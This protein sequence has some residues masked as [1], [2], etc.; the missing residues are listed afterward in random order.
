MGNRAL[1]QSGLSL[2][3]PHDCRAFACQTGPRRSRVL[4]LLALAGLAL[5]LGLWRHHHF[6]HD[7]AYVS[8]RYAERLMVGQ[9]LTWNDGER[10]EGFSSPSWVAQVALLCGLGI[11]LP[12]AAR[13]LGVVYALATLVLWYR[14]RAEPA[15]LLALVTVSGFTM[16]AWGGLE[17]V[18]ACFWILLAMVVV[19]RVGS[20]PMSSRGGLLFGLSLALVVLSRPEGIAVGMSL[21]C[22]AWPARRGRFFRIGAACLMVV[23]LAYEIFRLAYFGDWI[24]NGARAKTLG[25]PL[26]TR[27]E[28]AAIYLAKTAPQ[29]LGAVF[30]A[31]WMLAW[32]PER[33]RACWLLLPVVP[34]LLVVVLG[35]GDHMLGA[36]FM[37]A[38]VAVM[39]LAGSLAPPSPRRWVRYCTSALATVCALA[40]FQIAWRHPAAPNPA[41]AIGEI[42]GRALEARLTPGTLVATA[43]AGSVPYFAPSLAFIDTLG[44]NDRHIARQSPAIISAARDAAENWAGVPGHLRGDGDYV[45]SRRPEVIV[46]GG[47]NGDIAPWFLGDYQVITS[48]AFQGAYAPWRLLVAVPPSLRPWVADEI[49]AETGRLPVTLYVRRD[50]SAWSAIARDAAMLSPLWASAR[51]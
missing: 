1:V 23:F 15:G 32:S 18:A 24:A 44:L 6:F 41:A 22:A 42:V 30:V 33:K 34:L 40:Q 35:G 46:L 2:A 48:K 19:Q 37:L 45:L 51:E 8:L 26:G 29:W 31:G 43:T 11:S 7:D 39:C 10:L 17:T 38:P 12:L 3:T 21:L 49:D 50:T 13:L 27:V 47:A 9:G 36:R 25:L 16:W 20:Q 4:P 28:S 5:V 14:S